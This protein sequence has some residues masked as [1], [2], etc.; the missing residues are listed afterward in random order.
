MK[1]KFAIRSFEKSDVYLI[2]SS[3]NSLFS[4]LTN[5]R[6]NKDPSTCSDLEVF[7]F[8]KTVKINKLGEFFKILS[9][10]SNSLF[11][12]YVITYVCVQ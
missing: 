2:N 12:N 8:D 7:N 4:L 1:V 3:N 5:D 11:P 9:E 10:F 6:K